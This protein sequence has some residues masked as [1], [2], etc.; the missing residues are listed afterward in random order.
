MNTT[1]TS[2]TYDAI[3]IGSGIGGLT[4]GSLLAQL[5]GKRVLILERHFTFGGFTHVFSRKGF[6]W[7]VGIHYV[8]NMGE[9]MVSRRLMDLVTDHGVQWQ[10]MPERFDRFVYPDF[11]YDVPADAALYQQELIDRFPLEASGI[12]R[13]FRDVERLARWL[14][15]E[16]W[17]WSA[18]SYIQLPVRLATTRLRALGT[19]T[20]KAYL[21]RTFRDPR[22]KALLAS[23][24]GDYGLQPAE[25]AFAY[26]ALVTASYFRGAWYPVGGG[27]AF[28]D[29][30]VP[31]ITRHGGAC[32]VDHTVTQI[33]VEK[34]A[35]VGVRAEQHQ[36]RRVT[37]KVFRAPLVIS[38]AGAA[39][40]YETLL[41]AAWRDQRAELATSEE[42]PWSMISLYL[43][44]KVSP[45]TLGFTGE[46]IWLFN[47]YD[48]DDPG[49][50]QPDGS[51]PSMLYISFP[52][53]KDPA[54]T[55]HTVEI[56]MP[57]RYDHFAA[58]RQ[59]TWMRRGADY[60]QRKAR[61]ADRILEAVEA[62]YPG[63]RDLV[64]YHEVATPLTIEEFTGNAQG[65]IYGMPVTP[66]R[67][68]A[69]IGAANTPVKGLLLAGADAC[70]LGI[71]GAMMGGVFAVAAT[72]GPLGFPQL[73]RRAANQTT[74][75][76]PAVATAESPEAEKTVA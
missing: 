24:W 4:A 28:A 31:I 76:R 22:L 1:D 15:T 47:G 57:I 41:P 62:R 53:L 8:G 12:R 27:E 51:S 20:T 70:V 29:A 10:K 52:S 17:S 13:Y 46:N 61:I 55:A 39:I 3:V 9:D 63:L 26:H 25:S 56:L 6:T 33:L 75:F 59:T 60:E 64:V 18:P 16:T 32:L 14:G 66:Y 36:G 21:D 11:T 37:E 58:W 19:L 42:A 48:H 68:H 40:T 5:Q 72:M 50:N 7:D 65:A 49:Q 34:G 73:L 69:R 44:L 30:I 23:Q 35:A 71:E 45:A 2:E 67:L 43:G 54:S 74:S 38:D